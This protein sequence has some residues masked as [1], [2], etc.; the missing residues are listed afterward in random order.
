MP[1]PSF[2]DHSKNRLGGREVR[3]PRVVTSEY[4]GLDVGIWT[5][6]SGLS[7]RAVDVGLEGADAG[8]LGG[9]PLRGGC[10]TWAGCD[11]SK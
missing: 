4:V 6:G 8:S 2:A 1:P 9:C 10:A 3:P 7:D 5:C 11:S